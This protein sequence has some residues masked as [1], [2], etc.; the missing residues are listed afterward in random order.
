M[1]GEND[2]M[3]FLGFPTTYDVSKA[4]Q[5]DRFCVLHLRNYVLSIIIVINLTDEY[6]PLNIRV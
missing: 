5:S 3:F 6:L 4:I 2:F 1:I